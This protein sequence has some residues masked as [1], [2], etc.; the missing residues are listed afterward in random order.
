MEYYQTRNDRSDDWMEVNA[1]VKALSDDILKSFDPRDDNGDGIAED[2]GALQ[3]TR[4]CV[5]PFLPEEEQERRRVATRNAKWA[6]NINVVASI[7]LL[8][9]K[10]IGAKAVTRIDGVHD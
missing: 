10:A 4:G 1:I 5:E 9:A 2:G 6:I 7:T 3:D 8:I